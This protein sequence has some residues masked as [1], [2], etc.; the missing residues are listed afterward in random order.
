MNTY[1]LIHDVGIKKDIWYQITNAFGVFGVR[2]EELDGRNATI[3]DLSP[4]YGE[5]YRDELEKVIEEATVSTQTIGFD[6]GHEDKY[7]ILVD[8]LE[9][10]E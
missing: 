7:I 3:R 4:F 6:R 5:N 2:F 1:E 9:T 10:F 8:A